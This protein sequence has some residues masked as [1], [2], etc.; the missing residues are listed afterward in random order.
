MAGTSGGAKG[1]PACRDQ[2]GGCP[3]PTSAELC[4]QRCCPG[5]PGRRGK[6]T[7][8]LH[9]PPLFPA[10]GGPRSLLSGALSWTV[11]FSTQWGQ[12]LPSGVP[13]GGG[14]RAA[15]LRDEWLRG[16]EGDP[17]LSDKTALGQSVL[18]LGRWRGAGG[19][20]ERLL[21]SFKTNWCSSKTTNSPF[22]PASTC[23]RTP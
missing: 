4:S 11:P 23:S 22:C 1:C 7:R 15:S 17:P 12:H 21:L 5:Q 10:S 2:S 16:G 14:E 9:I 19:H 20:R 6:V 3:L 18:T 13:L 8:E